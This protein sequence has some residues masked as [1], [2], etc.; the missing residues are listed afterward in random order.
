MRKVWW[1]GCGRV[2][3]LQ[4]ARIRGDALAPSPEIHFDL[5]NSPELLHLHPSTV[6]AVYF[7]LQLDSILA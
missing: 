3:C 5:R 1:W 4:A 7:A 2:I 6:A